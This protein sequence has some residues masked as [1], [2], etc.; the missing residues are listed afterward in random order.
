MKIFGIIGWK[1]SGKTFLA[2]KIISHLKANKLEVASIKRAHHNFEIDKPGTDSFFHRQAGAN[3]VIISSSKRWAKIVELQNKQ[4][5]NLNELLKEL[6]SPDMV[7]VEGFKKEN[8]PK[9]EIIKDPKKP[10][11]YLFKK[12]KNVVALISDSKIDSSLMQ[13]NKNEIKNI[14]NFIINFKS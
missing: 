3:Q 7:I 14:V 9:I 5:K 10:S 4:E 8:H 11:T 2:Q 6:D 12:L 13:F 1:N